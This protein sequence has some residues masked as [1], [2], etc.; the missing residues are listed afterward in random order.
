MTLLSNGK[1]GVNI[2]SP[3]AYFHLPASTAAA[4]TAS[5][6]IDAGVLATTPVSGNIESDGTHL[7]WTNSAGTRIQ[8]DN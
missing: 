6:K 5:L 2:N 7:Y 1:I 8:L 3:S 4:N